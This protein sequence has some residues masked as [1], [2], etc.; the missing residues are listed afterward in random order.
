MW[1]ELVGHLTKNKKLKCVW[2]IVKG[3]FFSLPIKCDFNKNVYTVPY[4]GNGSYIMSELYY[5][6]N[7]LTHTYS[8]IG[9][10]SSGY[11]TLEIDLT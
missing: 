7:T 11:H 8:I 10:N 2:I 3:Q 4:I 6:S 9:W 1:F 5:F